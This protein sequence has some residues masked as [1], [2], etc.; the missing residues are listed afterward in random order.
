MKITVTNLVAR[1]S[2]CPLPGVPGRRWRTVA[3]AGLLAL[4]ASSGAGC[5]AN[6][7]AVG[8]VAALDSFDLQK[9][10]DD[11]AMKLASDPEVLAEVARNGPLTV[12]VQPVENRL[13]GEVLPRGQAEAFTARVRLLLSR[14]A[15]GRFT[16]VMNRDAFYNLRGRE[17]DLG[18]DDLGPAPEAVSPRF[19]L[20]ATFTSLA[21]V[22]PR[23]RSAY[24]YCLYQL[25]SLEDRG[26]L[27]SG[28]Y[29]VRKVAVKGFL[30]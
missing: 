9:M 21:D 6:A 10:T 12:V 28:S 16:W 25:T 17:L 4:L 8:Q 20:T 15:P 7:L 3:L 22:D 5:A 13:S 23:R 1:P 2:P 30:D 26:I 29:E 18:V 24:Y 27:W 14:S 19:A 11:M